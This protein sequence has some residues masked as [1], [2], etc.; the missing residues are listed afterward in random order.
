M[1]N[2]T[3]IDEIIKL[4]EDFIKKY[5]SITPSEFSK[6]WTK[7]I[8]KFPKSDGSLYS[9]EDIRKIIK[10]NNIS[11]SPLVNHFLKNKPTRTVSGVA[12][13]TIFTKPYKC[14]G[15]CIFC[16]TAV[17]APKSYLPEEPGV[18]RAIDLKYDPYMQILKRI[19]AFESIGHST[20]KIELIISGGTW[21]DYD[22]NYRI[23]FILEVFRALNRK[24]SISF[25]FNE[26][27]ITEN[28]LNELKALEEENASVKYRCVGLTI[29]TRPDKVNIKNIEWYRRFGVT[30]VQLGVQ[31]LD[32]NILELNKRGHS[33]EDSFQS[34][35]LLRD[36]GFKIHIH[37]MAN[38]F[39]SNIKKDLIDF[40]KI[41]SDER[42]RPDELKI[43]PTS[44]VEGTVLYNY[45][46][47][48]KYQPYSTDE[49]ILLLS[50]AKTFVQPYCRVTRLFRDI[51]SDLIIDGNKMTNLR[52]AVHRY[53]KKE[54][55]Q[56]KCIRCNEIR[57]GIFNQWSIDFVRY[58]TSSGQDY[59]IRALTDKNKLAGFLRLSIYRNGKTSL[60]IP[61]QAM[62]REVHVYGFAKKIGEQGHIDSQHRGIGTMLLL[63]AEKIAK[64]N[65]VLLLG[66]IAGVGTRNYYRNRG[67]K[68]EEQ[69]GYGIKKV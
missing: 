37:W 2:D 41:F 65:D 26:N 61:V 12:P 64:Q 49:L 57:G 68:I 35:K 51:P 60:L 45:Y 3:N 23:W 46:K 43:Y 8:R 1:M 6:E 36:A 50:Q 63:E 59:F 69:F 13:L 44:I 28:Y 29:E 10:D 34:I 56:C 24:K 42:I 18:Q 4:L 19:E 15:H 55:L 33:V 20:D 30:K 17:N 16:P 11:V 22:I 9:K 39:G 62:I 48:D 25:D 54:G 67:F 31:S 38:L 53:M 58:K 32:N 7:V 47:Q 40:K 27:Y 14:S 21:D 5:D 66:V 52:E